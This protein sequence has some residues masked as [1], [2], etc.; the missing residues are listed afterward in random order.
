MKEELDYYLVKRFPDFFKNRHT[1]PQESCMFWGFQCDDGWFHILLQSCELIENH[2][3]NIKSQNEFKLKM[4]QKIEAGEEV[5]ENWV[6]Q[7]KENGLVEKAVP[8]F[9][10][11]QIKEKFGTLRFYYDNGDDFISGVISSAESMSATTC[12]VCGNL[13]QIRYGGW[14]RTLCDKHSKEEDRFEDEDGEDNHSL[15]IGNT[16]IGLS[17]GEIKK[18]I[19]KERKEN[20]WIGK[21]QSNKYSN[22]KKEYVSIESEEDYFIKEVKLENFQYYDLTLIS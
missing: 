22:E 13:G 12:E 11:T 17:N 5:H 3:K 20:Q 6:K 4:K 10:A 18:I 14:V 16:I 2:L 19:V 8:Q 21:E 1:S 7:Y 9:N 15:M